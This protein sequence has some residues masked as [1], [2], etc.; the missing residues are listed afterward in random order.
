MKLLLDTHA[1][2]WWVDGTHPLSRRAKAKVADADTEVFLSIASSWEIAVTVS[3]GK[4]RLPKTPNRF[5]AEQ[6]SHNGFALLEASLEHVCRVADM[7][8]ITAIP[9]IACSSPSR[10]SRRFRSSATN[11]CSMR[12]A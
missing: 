12:M 6:V 1:F 5:I 11:V 2:L 8:S 7:R 10:S 3:L 4:L 9:S